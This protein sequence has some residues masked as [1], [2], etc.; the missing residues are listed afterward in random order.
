MD[1]AYKSPATCGE[2]RLIY[3]PVS[4]YGKP[5]ENGVAVSAR[6]PTTLNIVLNARNETEWQTV[7]CGE[8]ARRCLRW[9]IVSKSGADLAFS[10][11]SERAGCAG[12]HE[13][14]AYRPR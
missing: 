10:L 5:A 8:I 1:R 14:R 11:R 9:A 4:N 3:R 6:L 2:I 12:V 13:T 7:S